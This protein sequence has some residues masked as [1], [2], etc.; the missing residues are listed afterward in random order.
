[1]AFREATIADTAALVALIN[2]VYRGDSSRLGWTTEADLLGG[3]RTDADEVAELIAAADS[4]FLVS[5]DE[6]GL[7]GCAHLA[8]DGDRAWLGMFAVRP[9]RQGAGLG[10][11]LLQEAE[12]RVRA[13]WGV[14][15]LRMSVISVRTELIAYYLRRGFRLTGET[16]PFPSDPR[17]GTPK[18]DHLEFAVLERAL[19]A[20]G[21][22]HR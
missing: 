15:A 3:Q 11:V 8:R 12:R 6:S 18:V 4:F 19:H 21:L 17:F 20:S 14:T 16:L 7:L 22:T 2:S 9:G 10:R 1:M 13:R 5:E